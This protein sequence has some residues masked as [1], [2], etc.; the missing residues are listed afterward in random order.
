MS[1]GHLLHDYDEVSDK[2]VLSD[3]ASGLPVLAGLNRSQQTSF[4]WADTL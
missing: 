1:G 2:D 3:D 4:P